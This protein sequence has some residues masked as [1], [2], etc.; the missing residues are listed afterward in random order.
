MTDDP[1]A[2][3]RVT[4]RVPVASA[5]QAAKANVQPIIRLCT[6]CDEQLPAGVVRHPRCRGWIE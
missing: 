4:D 6:I 1:H 3:Y 2:A 5:S